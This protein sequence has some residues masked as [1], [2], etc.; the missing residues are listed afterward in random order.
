MENEQLWIDGGYL[1]D[2]LV[3]T[4]YK[5]TSYALAELI[6][7]SIE[8]A[9][10]NNIKCDC[11]IICIE[12]SLGLGERT[13]KRVKEILVYDNAGGMT[14]EILKNSLRIQKGS[15]TNDEVVGKGK[16]GKYGIGL[17]QAS[18]G[19]SDVVE[20]YSWRDGETFYHKLDKNELTNDIKTLVVPD[21]VKA[22]VPEKYMKLISSEIKKNGT[23]VIWSDVK[24]ATWTTNKGLFKNA[25]DTLGRIFR[26][27]INDG[28]VKIKLRAFEEFDNNLNLFRE[29]I[30]RV[31]D[32]LYLMGNSNFPSEKSDI[33]KEY[34]I[35][36]MK[37]KHGGIESVV[38]IKFS[39]CTQ[40]AR[41]KY[42]DEVSPQMR[43]LRKNIG[44]SICRAGREITISSSWN[45][46]YDPTDRW[47]G[48]EIDFDKS[49]DSLMGV[50]KDKQTIKHLKN[51]N[52][53]FDAENAGLSE[54]EYTEDLEQ[55]DQ[56]QTSIYEI[57]NV[58]NA[59]I[60]TIRSLLTKQTA[61]SRGNKPGGRKSAVATGQ[62]VKKRVF[63]GYTA[64][65]DKP[66]MTEIDKTKSLEEQ[67]KESGYTDEQIK[68]Y[69][70][71]A[72]EKDLNY[73]YLSRNI[74]GTALFDLLI[75]KNMKYILINNTHPLYE[76]F[77]QIVENQDLKG[78]EEPDS[79]VSI[80]LLISSWIRMEEETPEEERDKLIDVRARW[81]LISKQF[82]NEVKK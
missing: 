23:L 53:K 34:N 22:E 72:I 54:E 40:E 18:I 35:K 19:N 69:V 46:G 29:Q 57:S 82:F 48:C 63:A 20:I 70:K 31:N 78:E 2:T 4:D 73:I 81:G 8:S 80:R 50:T 42:S 10:E 7:N 75:D 44:V 12:K 16:L 56:N 32:P 66:V 47:W 11:E 51:C 30:I 55:S 9:I 3:T 58:I 60:S 33:F 45:R 24:R 65:G 1:R 64:P 61:G 13:I 76:Y 37:V 62:G 14:P 41:D 5:D 25:E 79:L 43:H 21:P 26:N 6:D 39:Y 15:R 68:E 49:L 28:S 59:Q 67:L 38:T 77:Y 36:K 71:Y 52:L 74:P 17:P 27:Y